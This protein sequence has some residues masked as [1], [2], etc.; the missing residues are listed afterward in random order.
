MLE[1]PEYE[2]KCA[3]LAWKDWPP[4]PPPP[5]EWLTAPWVPPPPPPPPPPPRAW[6][7]PWMTSDEAAIANMPA[8]ATTSRRNMDASLGCTLRRCNCIYEP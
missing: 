7:E 8:N 6:A 2:P 1:R 5:P 3:P 4:P